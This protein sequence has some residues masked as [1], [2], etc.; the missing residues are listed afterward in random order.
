MRMSFFANVIS[1]L[2][3]LSPLATS[4]NEKASVADEDTPQ[5]VPGGKLYPIKL[6]NRSPNDV[7]CR[8]G[9]A[10]D[11]WLSEGLPVEVEMIPDKS[12][13][14]ISIPYD[15][16]QSSGERRYFFESFEMYFICSTGKYKTTV[17]PEITTSKTVWLGT[18]AEKNIQANIDMMKGKDIELFVTNLAT[19]IINDNGNGDMLPSSYTIKLPPKT[20]RKW[21]DNIVSGLLIQPLREIKVDGTGVTAIEYK[22]KAMR[23][24]VLKHTSFLQTPLGANIFAVSLENE[25]LK[26]GQES[27]VVITHLE[28]GL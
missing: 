25:T 11:Y 21:H 17:N 23:P 7:L 9:E 28:R 8:N 6:S 3:C 19:T 4:A 24:V 5:I 22:V 20:L 2:L 14:M 10:I 15:V 12:G 27:S 1:L 16:N 26:S 13:W 18:G